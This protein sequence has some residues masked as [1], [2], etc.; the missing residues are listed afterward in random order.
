MGDTLV[1]TCFSSRPI[2]LIY[3]Y[4]KYRYTILPDM[5]W[6]T[7]FYQVKLNINRGKDFSGETAEVNAVA[8]EGSFIAFSATQYQMYEPGGNQFFREYDVRYLWCSCYFCRFH[9]L[10]TRQFFHTHKLPLA[11][12]SA[13]QFNRS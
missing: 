11:S 8:D 1:K 7:T 5:P 6:Y 12:H 4:N 10:P 9:S 3:L 13:L 2:F